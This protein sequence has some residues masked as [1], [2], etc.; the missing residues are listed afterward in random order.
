MRNMGF[1]LTPKSTTSGW[2]LE[3]KNATETFYFNSVSS[4]SSDLFPWVGGIYIKYKA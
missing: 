2:T 1:Q 4:E 3:D